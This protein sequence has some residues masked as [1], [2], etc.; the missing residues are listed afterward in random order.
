MEENLEGK[1]KRMRNLAYYKDMT[2]DEIYQAI[3][4][5]K[6][7]TISSK[8]NKSEKEYEERFE[9]KMKILKTD[10]GLDMNDSNDKEMAHN[11]VRQ[12]LQ[13]E[14][15]D[16]DVRVI[17]DKTE[18]TKD[19]ISTLKSLGDFQRNVQ[20]TISDLQDKLGISRKVRK[21]KA[22]D[23]IPQFI[24]GV[25]AKA[26]DFWQRKT[27]AVD[28]PRCQIELVRYW[29]NFPDNTSLASFTTECPQCRE[30]VIYN[31]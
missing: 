3:I 1:I 9:E 11:L 10:F 24:D 6:A 26:R 25:L 13:S 5:R 21:E 30:K 22:V 15:V 2:D 20:M 29:L 27:V 17:Q 8:P 28:C 16:R 23:D 14:N 19:D 31:A 18:K 12:L 7:S 4:N